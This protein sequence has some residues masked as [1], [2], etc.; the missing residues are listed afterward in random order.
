MFLHLADRIP[1]AKIL[2]VHHLARVWQATSAHPPTVDQN[3]ASTP[4]V[5]VTWLASAKSVEIPARDLAVATLTVAL[6]TTPLFAHVQSLTQATRSNIVC[7]KFKRRRPLLR[8]HV[9][10]HRAA[11]TLNATTASAPVC[12]SIKAILTEDVDPNVFSTPTVLEIRRAF[13]TSV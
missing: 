10:H 1:S 5:R 6:S 2:T 7:S 8:T 9:I 12:L 4:N 3:V 13:E 11:Q